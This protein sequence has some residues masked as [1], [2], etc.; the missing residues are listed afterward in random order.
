[1]IRLFQLI[2][3]SLALSLTHGAPLR[4]GG[5]SDVVRLEMR[6]GWQMDDGT[7]MVAMHLHL[8]PGWKTYWRAPGDAGL[9]PGFDWDGSV[10]LAGV[11]LH[12]PT[13]VAFWQAGMRSIGYER[14][15]VLPMQLRPERPGRPVQLRGEVHLG[16]CRDVCIPLDLSFDV[17]AAGSAR[18]DPVI[19]AAL[20]DRPLSAAEARVQGLGCVVEPAPDGLVLRLGMQMPQAARYGAMVI[21]TADPNIWVAEPSM[22]HAGDTITAT[23]RLIHASG[24]AFA[25]DRSGLRVTLL[26]AGQAVDIAGCPAPE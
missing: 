4:A 11:A 10:N 14:E 13:P 12:W 5:L 9:P 21:E 16:V 18:P 20:A 23:T 6:P 17:T 25:L 2:C 3:L 15:L 7:Y 22:D 8:A 19:K 1:M 26:G 24:G